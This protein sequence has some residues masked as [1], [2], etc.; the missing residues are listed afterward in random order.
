M[1]LQLIEIIK[2]V[3]QL[4]QMK[5]NRIWPLLQK[6]I[7]QTVQLVITVHMYVFTRLGI[8]KLKLSYF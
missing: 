4:N 3:A 6:N 2:L 1:L 7:N 8:D 5:Q